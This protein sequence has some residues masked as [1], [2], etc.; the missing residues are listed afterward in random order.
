MHFNT[1]LK[2]ATPDQKI[3]L[4][5]FAR[6]HLVKIL[7]NYPGQTALLNPTGGGV[8]IPWIGGGGG[9]NQPPP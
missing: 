1:F 2:V 4:I 5:F 9:L 7:T 3:T 6:K 8:Q